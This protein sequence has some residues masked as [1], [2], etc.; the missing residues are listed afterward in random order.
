MQQSAGQA[1]EARM[2]A[3]LARVRA[4]MAR[5]QAEQARA[6]SEAAAAQAG[7][8]Q[9][10]VSVLRGRD[11]QTI[12]QL[13]NGRTVI[14]DRDGAPVMEAPVGFPHEAPAGFPAMPI[15]E[16]GPPENVIVLIAVVLCFVAMTIVG[17]PIARAFA[18]RMDRRAVGAGT[19]DVDARLQRI[20]QA[21][22]AVA[23]EVERVSEAQRFSARLL[24][25]RAEPQPSYGAGPTRRP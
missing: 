10:E 5:A 17:L 20:E 16:R 13:P 7:G 12:V 15:E 9:R 21:V 14:I 23:V 19:T 22:E 4:E 24:A 25:E 2:D 11:G 8:E 1:Q 3:E 6:A 18:R